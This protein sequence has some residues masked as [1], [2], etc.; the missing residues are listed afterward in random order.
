M[1]PGAAVAP[2]PAEGTKGE[3]RP[4]PRTVPELLE[5]AAGFPEMGL[6][7]LDRTERE[8]L[9]TWD[10]LQERARAVAGGLAA[11]GVETG[12]RVGLVFST[13]PEFFFAYFG[14][15]LAGAVPVPLYPPVRLGRL[16][17][18]HRRT[19]R[20]I[21]LS[22]A[23]VVLAEGRVRRLLGQTM[24]AAQ[25]RLGCLRLEDLP[26]GPAPE[27]RGPAATPEAPALVQFSSGTTV[28]PKPVLLSH[29][30]LL[31]QAEILN[32]FW[33]DTEDVQVGGV[34][35][36]PLYHD[37][38]L[39]GCIFPAL[40]RP[41]PLT[42]LPPEAFVAR[43]ALW[44]R[45]ISRT[46]AVVSPAPNFAY[47]LC[48]DRVRDEELEGVDLS[49]WRVALNGAEPVAPRSLEA[50][51]QRF[52]R[53]GLPQTALTPVYG[54]SEAALAVSFSALDEPFTSRRF[55]RDALAAGHAIP[56]EDGIEIVSVGRPLPGFEVEIRPRDDDGT[57]LAKGTVLDDGSVGR[58]WVRGPSL[59]DGYLD[60][61]EA[62]A[63]AVVDGWLDTGDLAFRQD[64]QLFI[65]GRAKDMLLLRGRNLSPHEVERAV[66][67]VA[68][69]RTG[70]A[71]AASDLPEG[72][73]GEELV[74]LVEAARDASAEV[75]R[76]LPEACRQ[77]AL[78]GAGVRPDLVEILEPGTLPRTSSG[79]LR[80]GEALRLY[81][82]G[83][84]TAP[85]TVNA[86]RLGA[87][88]G[89]SALAFRRLRK[90]EDRG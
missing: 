85:K 73:E 54:L 68:G 65:T 15:N 35:W 74:L 83:E 16:D 81:R 72:A 27:L 9:V 64:G 20:M 58:L 53:F 4:R 19:A 87:A 80:R 14:A 39:I 75:R 90:Q 61:P 34:S 70:C 42:L 50:F 7:F 78:A 11:L 8:S 17:E 23:P 69:V 26:S 60:Q 25:P 21:E 76:E 43:P 5:R 77:A 86:L 38:G 31:A 2:T 56:E 33:P 88:L 48:A 84:L 66:D 18:Y 89:R 28:D 82:A 29:R 6:S 36:L 45:A 44:L 57:G 71:V 24:A 10:E 46:R 40:E 12:D 30:A 67:P 49:C 47:S 59:M 62:T 3:P 32:S 41:A 55:D 1:S 52:A 22:G 51:Q 13:S 79:K 63:A 37:M